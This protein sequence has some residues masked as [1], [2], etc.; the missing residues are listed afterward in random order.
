MVNA[1]EKGY[2][3]EVEVR[4]ECE[5]TLGKFHQNDEDFEKGCHRRIEMVTEDSTDYDME[6]LGNWAREFGRNEAKSAERKKIFEGREIGIDEE[7]EK[8]IRASERQRIFEKIEN[9]ISKMLLLRAYDLKEITNKLQEIT[10]FVEKYPNE[11]R[12]KSLRIAVEKVMGV[13]NEYK[14]IVTGIKTILEILKKKE[15]DEK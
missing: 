4:E 12:A 7:W 11:K 14:K 8:M 5:E 2:R 10:S 3:W 1:R 15:G 6:D 9:E 13:T